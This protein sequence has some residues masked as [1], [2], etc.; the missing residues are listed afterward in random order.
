MTY[1]TQALF[2]PWLIA[3]LALGV[4]VGW[5][6][7]RKKPEVLGLGWLTA[8]VAI[9]VFALFVAATLAI[10]GRLGLWFDSAL[11]FLVWYIVGCCLGTLLVLVGMR[12]DRV[13]PVAAWAR[14]CGGRP[15]PGACALDHAG[16]GPCR[17]R[18]SYVGP[19]PAG[20]ARLAGRRQ[21]R[22]RRR[23]D[24]RRSLGPTDRSDRAC[25]IPAYPYGERACQHPPCGAG[26]HPPWLQIIRGQD[27]A[28]PTP[29]P[30]W[31]RPLPP[32][33][34]SA[35]TELLDGSAPWQAVRAAD[36]VTLTGEVADEASRARMVAAARKTLK[37]L[38]V[39]DQLRIGAGST[40]L[41]TMAG[42]AF[43]PPREARS[44]PSRASSRAL[45]ADRDRADGGETARRSRLPPEPC[46]QA[47]PS[48]A[49]TSP[50]RPPSRMSSMASV[51]RAYPPRATARATTSSAS[52]ASARRTRAGSTASASGI[53][54]RSR[55][56]RRT[57]R[58]GSAPIAPSRAGS[59]ARTGSARRSCWR[60]AARR[61]SQ[62][63]WTTA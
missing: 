34:P 22:R 25:R 30:D 52:A 26:L 18:R 38:A 12:D 10:P 41:E 36:G 16:L 54:T 53:S 37:P 14:R 7:A 42:T 8:G 32:G 21:E 50:L 1:L 61:N 13:E 28:P 51:R 47:S 3:A 35:A 63:A 27:A 39:T 57:M 23:T 59:S 9:F 56:G 4:I 44:R 40:A 45:H 31:A 2:A 24:A 62:G 17:R 19:D 5:K 33:S 11:H 20:G 60:P 15:A 49:S 46:Q 6:S 48:P 58:C 43:G 29:V 55:A